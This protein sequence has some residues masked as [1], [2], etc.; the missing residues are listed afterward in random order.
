[1]SA[2]SYLDCFVAP[3]L[4]SSQRRIMLIRLHLDFDF[5]SR[6]QAATSDWVRYAV[7]DFVS[8]KAPVHFTALPFTLLFV[9]SDSVL[10]KI[11]SHGVLHK[12]RLVMTGSEKLFSISALSLCY[13]CPAFF[14]PVFCYLTFYRC[15][16][17][18]SKNQRWCSVKKLLS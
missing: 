9:P 6:L 12:N 5:A 13:R 1:M 7:L 15:R 2:Y 10:H 18:C 16:R 17:G 3:Y 11:R 8:Q 4:R 14:Q